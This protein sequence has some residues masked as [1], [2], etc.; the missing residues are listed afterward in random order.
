[1]RTDAKLQTELK[2][3]KLTFILYNRLII[4]S[5]VTCAKKRQVDVEAD[6]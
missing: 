3:C 6:R 1:M 5:K 4:K 2:K